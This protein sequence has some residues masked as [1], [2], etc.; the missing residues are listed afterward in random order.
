[1]VL[2]AAGAERSGVSS[3]RNAHVTSEQPLEMMGGVTDRRSKLLKRKW[4]VS[5][6]DQP[7]CLGD[8][9]TIPTDFVRAAAQAGP[10]PRRPASLPVHVELDMFALWPPR[11]A[12]RLAIDARCGDGGD[13]PPVPA[14][15]APLEGGPGGIRIDR[16]HQ[17][18][19][20]IVARARSCFPQ[21]AV[22]ANIVR[23]SSCIAADPLLRARQPMRGARF[24]IA[25]PHSMH[26]TFLVWSFGRVENSGGI[27]AS[28]AGRYASALFD[29]AREQ[30]QI[31]AVSSS[32]D[33]LRQALDESADFRLLVASPLIDRDD[34][35][36]AFAAIAGALKLDPVST[37]FL[38]V[39]AGNGRK[40]ELGPVI[41]A[42]RQLAAA[43]RGETTAEVT[44]ARPLGDGQIDALRK[45]LKS[46]TGRDV[47]IDASVDPS[48]LG[49]LVVKLGSQMIDA[50]IRTKLNRLASA[51]KG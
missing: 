10:I 32:L 18:E 16:F 12:A 14:P 11:W 7:D 50:S 22:K 27:Q 36:K 17:H 30:R 8:R 4:L 37:N 2:G 25:V 41:R 49:G 29:L 39:L 33:S 51:M 35:G 5:I 44:S 42:F 3:G 45:Q 19:S 47:T 38:G 21:I 46:R 1:M 26:G 40:S 28:L 43:H 20:T 34:A 31:D 6:V 48:I 15:V 23:P 13:D 9:L 24:F